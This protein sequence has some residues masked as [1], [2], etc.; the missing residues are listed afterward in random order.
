MAK[1]CSPSSVYGPLQH[2]MFLGCSV[3]SFSAN[4]GWNEDVSTVDINLVR[5]PCPSSEGKIYYDLSSSSIQKTW[6]AAD[7]GLEAFGPNLNQA[8]QIGAPAYFRFGDFEFTGLIQTYTKHDSSQGKDIY[9]VRLV[10]PREI[11]AGCEVIIGDYAGSVGNVFNLFNAYG[12]EENFRGMNCSNSVSGRFG[13]SQTNENGMPFTLIRDAV[14]LLT[15]ASPPINGSY[16]AYGRILYRG[17]APQRD[18]RFGLLQGDAV[19]ISEPINWSESF[20]TDGYLAAYFLDIT[21]LPIMPSSY[22]ITG[23]SINLLDLIS[24]ICSDAGCDY[25][26]EIV[27]VKIG[28]SVYKFIKVRI[29]DR[30]SQPNLG[31]I[32]SYINSLDRPLDKS[33]GRELRN[34]VHNKFL[35]GG[36]ERIIFQATQAANLIA[37]YWGIGSDGSIYTT[38]VNANDTWS[39]T[40]DTAAINSSLTGSLSFNTSQVTIHEWEL[41]AALIDFDSWMSFSKHN[42]TNIYTALGNPDYWGLHRE[43]GDLLNDNAAAGRD[44][45]NA[46]AKAYIKNATEFADIQKVY[47]WVKEFATDYYGKRFAV[48][49]IDNCVWVNSDGTIRELFSPSDGGWTET[50]SVI[51]L[52]NPSVFTDFFENDDGTL[53]AFVRFDSLSSLDIS[54]LPVDSYAYSGNQIWVKVTVLPELVYGDYPNRLAPFVVV[55]L[56]GVVKAPDRDGFTTNFEWAAGMVHKIDSDAGNVSGAQAL[57]NDSSEQ[58]YPR[59][60]EARSVAI[61]AAAAIPLISHVHTYGPWFTDQNLLQSGPPGQTSVEKDDGLVPWNFGSLSTLNTAGIALVNASTSNMQVGELGNITFAGLPDIPLGAEI[62]SAR[63]ITTSKPNGGTS[64][65]SGSNSSNKVE[66]RSFSTS[67]F[68]FT[69]DDTNEETN[70]TAFRSPFSSWTGEFGPNVTSINVSIAEDGIKTTYS[71]RTFTSKRGIFNKLFVDRIKKNSLLRREQQKQIRL[72]NF[73]NKLK[74]AQRSLA[75][76]LKGVDQGKI[77]GGAHQGQKGTPH[78]VLIG[79]LKS[80]D[81]TAGSGS[82]EWRRTLISDKSLFDII[83]NLND[84]NFESYAMMSWDGLIRPVSMNGT[85]SLPRYFQVLSSSCPK[86]SSTGSIPPLEKPGGGEMYNLQIDLN[87]LNPFSNPV[88][89]SRN[90]INDRH[91]GDTGHDIE[92]V[93][94]GTTA[95]YSGT[96]DH[97]SMYTH[98]DGYNSANR[99]DYKSDYRF[100]A[101]RGPLVIQGWGYDTNGKPIPN[102][103]DTENTAEIGVFTAKNLQDK[104]FPEFLRKP[105]TWPVAPVDLRFDRER[106]CW[107]SPP[108]HLLVELTLQ[109]N[110]PAGGSA[111]AFLNDGPSLYDSD[112]NTITYGGI[113]SSPTVTVHDKTQ[114]ALNSGAQI[115]GYYNPQKCEYWVIEAPPSGGGQISVTNSGCINELSGFTNVNKFVFG[116]GLK[117]EYPN[118]SGTA[119]IS[120]AITYNNSTARLCTNGLEEITPIDSDFSNGDFSSDFGSVGGENRYLNF[121]RI[122]FGEGIAAMTSSEED[123]DPCE[124]HFCLAQNLYSTDECY[125]P[126]QSVNVNYRADKITFGQGLGLH[127]GVDACQATVSLTM[128]ALNN[129]G[130]QVSE[131]ISRLKAGDGVIFTEED[132][133]SNCRTLLIRASG[134]SGTFSATKTF[135]GKCHDDLIEI[136]NGAECIN[137]NCLKI[138]AGLSLLTG[139]SEGAGENNGLLALAQTIE[140]IDTC[141]DTDRAIGPDHGGPS[142]MM[143]D[144]LLFGQGLGVHSGTTEC[145]AVISLSMTALDRGNDEVSNTIGKLKEGDGIKFIE[146]TISSCDILEIETSGV[147]GKFC[148]MTGINCSLGSI[149][150]EFVELEFK[151]G[152]LA[153]TGGCSP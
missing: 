50:S 132:A 108:A 21:D 17:A 64:F 126:L 92:I 101:L 13:G 103:N 142:N 4:L 76:S 80:W 96:G 116:T 7:P 2:T 28:N 68:T 65:F 33:I 41:K 20:N 73:V 130:G 62:G 8:P 118:E 109:E 42:L 45:V 100:M 89:L 79:E 26:L 31:I 58:E 43:I 107:V 117:V 131:H 91:D 115:L 149:E 27:P 47:N 67:S 66:N 25:Y 141:F 139:T 145:E 35:V 71:M 152:V 82:G 120:S 44:A 119:I 151:K 81:K 78:S 84:T 1:V 114:T 97:V 9:T 125:N 106:G 128:V 54:S 93:G 23:S 40:V 134:G 30:S 51:G 95:D 72:L 99:G 110:L 87:Y 22:R 122:R 153:R 70:Y 46:H 12:F 113:G 85:G 147:T 123:G 55:E 60:G 16:S 77:V 32:E 69:N 140:N 63:G 11:L 49:V 98:T 83:N 86:G 24:Q 48:R 112:G 104:F 133:G 148:L 94:R 111:T 136:Q 39:F 75:Q 61:P 127:S 121:E 56:P 18:S 135:H 137:L 57:V 10:D 144:K 105:H 53:G 59:Q 34:E 129:A 36:N 88:G 52:T 5:D 14:I 143:V 90:T 102:A 19:N 29:A 146:D 74:L 6:F 15:S 38:T 150:G 37:P 3:I 138:G 124:V